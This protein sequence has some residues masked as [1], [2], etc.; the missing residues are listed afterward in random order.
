MAPAVAARIHSATDILHTP[1][2][3]YHDPAMRFSWMSWTAWYERL[4]LPHQ[5][6]G[7]ASRGS[8]EANC[9]LKAEFIQEIWQRSGRP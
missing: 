8:W 4:G 5:V 6:I 2:L 1:L 3:V 7:L 9:S